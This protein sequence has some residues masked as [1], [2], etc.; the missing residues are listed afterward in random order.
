MAKYG[1]ITGFHH[2]KVYP[3]AADQEFNTTQGGCWV[4]M[5]GSGFL[6]V[7]LTATAT[8]FGFAI[9]PTG[10]TGAGTT[11]GIWKS[12]AT[13][14]ADRIPVIRNTDARFLMPADDTVTQAMIGNACDL[15]GVNDGTLQKADVGTSSTD[16]VVIDDLGINAGGN[17]TDVVVKLNPAKIQAD[18]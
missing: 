8:L 15:I 1:C 5:N 14:G 16:V 12:S 10:S 4:I 13:A 2:S 6:E 3:V 17:T 9:A 11:A 7:A 18:T